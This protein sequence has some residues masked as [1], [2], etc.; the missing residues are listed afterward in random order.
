L[1][2]ERVVVVAVILLDE[3]QEV[4]DDGGGS[5]SAFV[6]AVVVKEAIQEDML[7]GFAADAFVFTLGK[8]V[9]REAACISWEKG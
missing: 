6:V 8:L 9:W 5:D 2:E 3:S 1:F 7:Q 4:I